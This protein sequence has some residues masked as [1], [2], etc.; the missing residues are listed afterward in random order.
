MPFKSKPNFLLVKFFFLMLSS[1][2]KLVA[3]ISAIQQQLGAKT[4]ARP[5]EKARRAGRN[6]FNRRVAYQPGRTGQPVYK[7][8]RASKKI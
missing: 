2:Y 4:H 6:S 5:M 7:L 1:V 3:R 8:K